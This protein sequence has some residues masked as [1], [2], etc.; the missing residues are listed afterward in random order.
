MPTAPPIPCLRR[1]TTSSFPVLGRNPETVERK[2]A[3]A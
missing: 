1:R 2:L 3:C